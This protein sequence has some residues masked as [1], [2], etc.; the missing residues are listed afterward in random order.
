[1]KPGI[2][3]CLCHPHVSNNGSDI[4]VTCVCCSFPIYLKCLVGVQK[5][6][7][8]FPLKN[9]FSWLSEFL[10]QILSVFFC[11]SCFYL[12]DSIASDSVNLLTQ[13][14]YMFSY[15]SYQSDTTYK[16]VL[17]DDSFQADI[18]FLNA[19]LFYSFAL[20]LNNAVTEVLEVKK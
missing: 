15:K 9:N 14:I 17:I 12:K 7:S 1:M 4:S 3:C 13:T 18:V 10:N 6:N 8:R 11:N 19:W 16:P 5:A 20:K 2:S